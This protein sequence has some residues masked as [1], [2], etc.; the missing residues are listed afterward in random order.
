MGSV[1]VVCQLRCPT[2]CGI[3]PDQGMNLCPLYWQADSYP[4]H[5]QGSPGK[6]YFSIKEWRAVSS[7][8]RAYVLLEG[9]WTLWGPGG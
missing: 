6:H 7:R 3:F 1:V 9:L 4:L 8:S 2:A 5:Q